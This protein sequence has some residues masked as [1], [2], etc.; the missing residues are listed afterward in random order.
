L[1]DSFFEQ[2]WDGRFFGRDFS[3]RNEA[4]VFDD[5]FGG[6]WE[7]IR[8]LGK[9]IGSRRI[10][11]SNQKI[12]NS[13]I[14]Y[15]FPKSPHPFPITSKHIIKHSSPTLS[16]QISSKNPSLPVLIKKQT[17]PCKTSDFRPKTLPHARVTKL[18]VQ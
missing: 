10:S 1:F 12:Q 4:R 9:K 14:S 3:L 16:F 8:R 17:N 2:K 11:D 5:V 18:L 13:P 15:L 6:Y 7:R